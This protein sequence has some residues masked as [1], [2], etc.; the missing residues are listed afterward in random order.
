M[1]KVTSKRMT[2]VIES[3]FVVFLIGELDSA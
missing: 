3:D 1:T 2:A